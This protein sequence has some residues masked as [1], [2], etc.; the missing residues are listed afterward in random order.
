M[1]EAAKEGPASAAAPAGENRSWQELARG[2]FYQRAYELAA[3]AGFEA[4]CQRASAEETLMLGDAARLSGRGEHAR[5]A[6]LSVRGRFAGSDAA[7]RAAFALGRLAFDSGHASAAMPWFDA[8]L[9]QN[10]NGPLALAA[11]DRLLEASLKLGDKPRA[12][13]VAK[14]YVA[15]NP[16][17]P[18]AKDAQR[19]LGEAKD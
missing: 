16:G 3:R 15:R 1:P 10:P 4:E 12:R 9:A 6:Y 17:G 5:H 2:G 18:H 19:I 13:Q 14:M 11:L 7:A 8:Y